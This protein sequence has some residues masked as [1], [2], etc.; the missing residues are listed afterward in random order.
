MELYAAFNRL[1]EI[2]EI[3]HISALPKLM[4]LDLSGNELCKFLDYRSYTIFLVKK[5]KVKPC[6]SIISLNK[7]SYMHHLT[8]N[9]QNTDC[10]DKRV[11]KFQ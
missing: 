2:S 11:S 7:S 8:K 9:I 10:I 5:L 1:S 6:H 3:V 4:V